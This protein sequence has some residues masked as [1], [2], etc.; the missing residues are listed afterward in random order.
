MAEEA[1][2]MANIVAA[3]DRA[4][5]AC[6][7]LDD[8][9]LHPMMQRSLQL[10]VTAAAQSRIDRGK[11]PGMA[12]KEQWVDSLAADSALRP[13]RDAAFVA[14][15]ALFDMVW[16]PMTSTERSEK[17]R[18][19]PIYRYDEVTKGEAARSTKMLEAENRHLD[20][21]DCRLG[22]PPRE[23]PPPPTQLPRASA[24]DQTYDQPRAVQPAKPD[25]DVDPT[26]AW[27]YHPPKHIRINAIQIGSCGQLIYHSTNTIKERD[28]RLCYHNTRATAWELPKKS[29]WEWKSF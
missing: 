5:D 28:S 20:A 12:H 11:R 29:A 3:L 1:N 18:R 24:P 17:A 13:P 21:E 4:Q 9:N 22:L 10:A 2:E 27:L 7:M 26:F 14:M 23:P 19:D 25:S 16:R 8:S 6:E 15:A